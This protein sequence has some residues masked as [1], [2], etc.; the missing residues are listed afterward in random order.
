MTLLVNLPTSFG[1]H[2]PRCVAA[3]LVAGAVTAA[4]ASPADYRCDNGQLLNA[5]MTPRDAKLKLDGQEYQL[6]RVRDRADARFVNAAGVTLTLAKSQAELARKDQP[7][8]TCKKVV[9]SLEPEVLN[10]GGP[11]KPPAGETASR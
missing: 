2:L 3:L 7:T 11:R 5:T 9:A 8:L 6:K 1:A 4:Q 10:G